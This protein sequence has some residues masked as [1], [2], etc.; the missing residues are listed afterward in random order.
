ML[1]SVCRHRAYPPRQRA[2][3]LSIDQTVEKMKL[4]LSGN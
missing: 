1:L 2:A 3:T 4:G